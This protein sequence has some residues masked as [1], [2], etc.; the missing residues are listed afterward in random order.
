MRTMM[1]LPFVMPEVVNTI[2]KEQLVEDM[3][4]NGRVG[5]EWNK[6]TEMVWEDIQ[7]AKNGVY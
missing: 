4:T 5:E 6:I 7:D 2:T 3:T 1:S